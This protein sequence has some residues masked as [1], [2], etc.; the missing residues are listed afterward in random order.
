MVKKV[1]EKACE[2][3]ELTFSGEWKQNDDI[4]RCVCLA[5]ES[6]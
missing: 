1:C 3:T 2:K 4:A 6:I 5:K